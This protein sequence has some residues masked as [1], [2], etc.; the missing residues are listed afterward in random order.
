M[1]PD[2]CQPQRSRGIGRLAHGAFR[3]VNGSATD[4]CRLA[5]VI[6][7]RR[8]KNR[9]VE[10]E[11]ARPARRIP[12]RRKRIATRRSRFD[13][14][15]QRRPASTRGPLKFELAAPRVV[16]EKE[17][18]AAPGRSASPCRS[19]YERVQPPERINGPERSLTVTFAAQIL[20]TSSREIPA[21][22]V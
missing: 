19:S 15:G 4:A 12:R 5:L 1:H 22:R 20:A 17:G 10:G 2:L 7:E 21:R 18:I 3:R 11:L 6:G 13:A 16:P 9:G 8:R 14:R